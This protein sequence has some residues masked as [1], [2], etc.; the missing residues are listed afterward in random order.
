LYSGGGDA[1][2]AEYSRLKG[3]REALEHAVIQKQCD[4]AMTSKFEE[5]KQSEPVQEQKDGTMLQG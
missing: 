2:A 4:P 5:P 3:Q 1:R